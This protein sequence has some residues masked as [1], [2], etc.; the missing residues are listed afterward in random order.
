MNFKVTLNVILGIITELLY[1]A[2]IVA[3]AFLICLFI[4][5]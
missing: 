2:A 1:A 4:A 3:V 5:P